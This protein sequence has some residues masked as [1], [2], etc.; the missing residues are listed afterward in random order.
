MTELTK[1]QIGFAIK[2][3]SR[4]IR[5][6][7]EQKKRSPTPA[8]IDHSALLNRLL[9]GKEPLP[10]PPP[11]FF[12][13]P[14]YQLEEGEPHV[15]SSIFYHFNDRNCLIINQGNGWIPETELGS[16]YVGVVIYQPTGKKYFLYRGS[17]EAWTL[18]EDKTRAMRL[19]PSLMIRKINNV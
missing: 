6:L 1:E 15:V 13:Y 3:M 18:Q 7:E 2:A 11:L 14:A 17:Y 5:I 8:D 10:E 4:Y 19:H 12:G 9:S 16:E